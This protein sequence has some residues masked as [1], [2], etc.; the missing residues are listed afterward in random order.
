MKRICCL[1]FF[2]QVIFIS[3]V[4]QTLP[5]V[6]KSPMDMSYYPANYPVLKIQDKVTEPLAARILY[7]RPQ[8]TGRVIFGG[9]VKYGEV[10]RLGANEATEIEFFKPVKIDGKKVARG[11]YTLYAIVNE[12]NWTFIFNKDT[13]T[14]GS[15]KYDPKKDLLRSTVPV[16]KTDTPLEALAMGFEK[17]TTGFNLVVAWDTVKAA[18]PISL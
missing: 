2:F 13:D 17:T 5:P 12:G 10:W 14:W 7:S 18:L 1:L 9:L 6:D 15:F 3:L 8:K 4:A 16:Q 11:R